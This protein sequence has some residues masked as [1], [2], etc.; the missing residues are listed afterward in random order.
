MTKV[1][2][3]GYTEGITNGSKWDHMEIIQNALLQT[4]LPQSS[5][6]YVELNAGAGVY[7]THWKCPKHLGSPL[8]FLELTTQFPQVAFDI[9]LC[10][11]DNNSRT[12][13]QQNVAEFSKKEGVV[14]PVSF[15]KDHLNLLTIMKEFRSPCGLI[16]SDENGNIPQ[17]DLFEKMGDT[18]C[19]D[20]FDFLFYLKTKTIKRA[21][22]RKSLKYGE[23]AI[24]KRS[25]VTL[26]HLPEYLKRMNRKHWFIRDRVEGDRHGFILLYGSNNYR[27]SFTDT[28]K[29]I[30]MY[31]TMTKEGCDIL[32]RNTFTKPELE[33]NTFNIK[34]VLCG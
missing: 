14:L 13:L 30:G 26:R 16:V 29:E 8:R 28:V 25:G 33:S 7:Q 27:P 22:G 31:H 11:I 23:N 6:K 12:K 15:W 19:L 4:V 3:M 24:I 1:L 34:Q 20:N 18:K 17:F 9:H 32:I 2:S 5:Y 21:I 10:E